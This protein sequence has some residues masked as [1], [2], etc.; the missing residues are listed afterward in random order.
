MRHTCLAPD[1]S[2]GC[3]V[4]AEVG[5]QVVRQLRE[6]VQRDAS[7]GGWHLAICL[8]Q[9]VVKVRQR[10]KSIGKQS[11][12]QPVH[13]HQVVEDLKFKQNCAK[14]INEKCGFLRKILIFILV[15]IYLWKNLEIP[16]PYHDIIE[17]LCFKF[18][19]G[20]IQGTEQ[21]LSILNYMTQKNLNH[22]ALMRCAISRFR[23]IERPNNWK[24]VVI[25]ISFLKS[26][27]FSKNFWVF[28]PFFSTI[29]SPVHG[30]G[31]KG[32]RIGRRV[33]FVWWSRAG[34][35]LLWSPCP[36]TFYNEKQKQKINN[37]S[38]IIS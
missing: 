11:M 9:K 3:G 16:F 14:K 33:A 10:A 18:G 26:Q 20:H 30:A 12:A 8:C 25:E 4:E 28:S 36:T 7:V 27:N 37:A 15:P 13:L 24:I 34:H 23:S 35:N 32:F 22:T 5:Q 2:S 31:V 6:N 1:E 17:A 38:K 29:D 21:S 19:D